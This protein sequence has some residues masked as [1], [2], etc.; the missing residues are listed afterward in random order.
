MEFAWDEAKNA[1]NIRKHEIDFIDAIEIFQHPIFTYIDTR[2]NYEEERWIGIGQI[3]NR[4]IVVVYI[5]I[6]NDTIRIVSARKATK[7]EKEYYEKN[8][9][10]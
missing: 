6:D 5:E 10:R 9:I 2:K 7:R 3:L 4:I 1:A 8:C